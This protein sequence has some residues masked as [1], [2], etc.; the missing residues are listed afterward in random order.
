MNEMRTQRVSFTKGRKKDS[1]S[2]LGWEKEEE[3]EDEEEEEYDDV[4]EEGK[5]K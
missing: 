5:N 1:R 4:D 3:E 2:D